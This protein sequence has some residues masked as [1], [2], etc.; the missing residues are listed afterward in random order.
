MK[1]PHYN[2]KPRGE[3]RD[4]GDRKELFP[5]LGERYPDD[6][7]HLAPPTSTWRRWLLFAAGIATVW[8]VVLRLL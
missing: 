4:S 6:P 2:R 1:R 5:D 7:P 8:V 3:W